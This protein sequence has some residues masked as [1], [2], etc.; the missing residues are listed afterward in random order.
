[1]ILCPLLPHKV[2]IPDLQVGGRC[3]RAQQTGSCLAARKQI[4]YSELQLLWLGF[5]SEVLGLV[6][7]S[8]RKCTL[9]EPQ[10]GGLVMAYVHRIDQL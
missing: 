1:M 8:V 6:A 3:E 4:T 2:T 10:I 5:Q 7:D 9:R